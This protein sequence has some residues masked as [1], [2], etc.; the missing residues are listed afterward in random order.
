MAVFYPESGG[1]VVSGSQASLA[2]LDPVNGVVRFVFP[3]SGTTSDR[4]AS[5]NFPGG[6]S[7]GLTYINAGS[8]VYVRP[9]I[10]ATHIMHASGAQVY[11]TI[12]RLV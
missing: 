5:V 11:F 10:G 2:G 7:A 1:S 12:G 8:E 6:V 9:P 3:D 4:V